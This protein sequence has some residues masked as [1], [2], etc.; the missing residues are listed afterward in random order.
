MDGTDGERANAPVDR[1]AHDATVNPPVI[2]PLS[3][4]YD[5]RDANQFRHLVPNEHNQLPPNPP[6]GLSH[7]FVTPFPGYMPGVPPGLFSLNMID[8]AVE[9]QPKRRRRTNYRDPE[10]AAKLTTALGILIKQKEENK[11]QDLK[12]IAS[13]F[14]LPYNTLRDNYLKYVHYA[15]WCRYRC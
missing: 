11:P 3:V 13:H 2:P 6:Y 14:G 1:T 5:A 8:D 7:P 15:V 9:R 10:N 12:S 4:P